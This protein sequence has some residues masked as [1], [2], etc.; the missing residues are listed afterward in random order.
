MQ[1]NF[2]GPHRTWWAAL[3]TE[4]QRSISPAGSVIQHG[5]G[6]PAQD[7][8]I[9]GGKTKLKLHKSSFSVS[10]EGATATGFHLRTHGKDC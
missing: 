8:K 1:N 3:G 2:L 6:A 4:C 5:R 10:L 9:T 7:K